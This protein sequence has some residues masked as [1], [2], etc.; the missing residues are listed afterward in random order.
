[1]AEWV[2]DV[3]VEECA[4]CVGRGLDVAVDVWQAEDVLVVRYGFQRTDSQQYSARKLEVLLRDLG[5]LANA[6]AMKDGVKLLPVNGI[7]MGN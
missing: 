5:L 2:V 6:S 7:T 1:M 3:G 4:G